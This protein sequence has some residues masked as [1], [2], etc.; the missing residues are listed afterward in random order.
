MEQDTISM[1]SLKLFKWMTSN[2]GEIQETKW[3]NVCFL[4]SSLVDTICVEHFLIVSSATNYKFIIYLR[5]KIYYIWTN[6]KMKIH[7]NIKTNT[8]HKQKSIGGFHFLLIVLSCFLFPFPMMKNVVC[9]FR[10]DEFECIRLL[11]PFGNLHDKNTQISKIVCSIPNFKRF[12]YKYY[13]QK[14]KL[15]WFI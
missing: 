6:K 13:H 14:K 7:G 4:R 15:P 10:C 2:G 8:L 12:D 5:Y 9:L 11:S 1:E 3:W